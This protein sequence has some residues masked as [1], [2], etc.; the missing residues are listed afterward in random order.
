MITSPL[1]GEPCW[2]RCFPRV[3]LRSTRGYFQSSLGEGIGGY[4]DRKE[5]CG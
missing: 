5:A 4:T 2:L 3:P 1:W